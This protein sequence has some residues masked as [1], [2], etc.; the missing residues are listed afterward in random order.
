MPTSRAFIRWTELDRTTLPAFLQGIRLADANPVLEPPRSY[1]GYPRWPLD[2]LRP[3]RLA[4]LDRA[5]HARRSARELGTDAPTRRTLSRLLQMAHG[6]SADHHRGPTPSAGGLQA[7]ELYVAHW[8]STWLPAGTYHYDRVG[9][10]LSQLAPECE[11]THWEELVPALRQLDGGALL[12]VLVGNAPRV[13]AKYGERGY[14]FLLLEA[15]HLM[16]NLCLLS[17]SLGLATVP[18]GGGLEGEIALELRLP[19]TDVVLYVAACGAVL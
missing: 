16:Q 7:L 8:S 19:R 13:T 18:L 12:W 9:Q 10:H 5:L 6:I 17:T 3:R 11:R 14:R 1:P 4:S 2:R 15:G